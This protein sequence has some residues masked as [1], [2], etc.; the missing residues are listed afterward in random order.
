MK[1]EYDVITV[2]GGL[3]GAA[4]AKVLADKGMRVLVVERE[5]QFKDRIRGEYIAPWGVAEAERIGLADTLRRTCAHE[6]PLF[7]SQGQVRDLRATT[8]QGLPAFTLYHPAMQEAVLDAARAA[9]AEVWRGATVSEVRPGAPPS[10]TVARGGDARSLTARLIVAADGR[11]SAA[12]GWGGFTTQRA[13]Q[14]LL[15]AGVMLENLSVPEDTGHLMINSSIGRA[16]FMFPQ[17]DGRVRA[18]L[19]YG[20]DLG[21]IQGEKDTARFIGE[22]MKTGMPA[23]MYAGARAGGP[24]AS[25]DM[26]ETWV[27]HPYR[28]GLALLGDAAGSSDPTWGQGLSLT[29]R[30][31]RVLSDN[32]LSTED[33]EAAGHSYA[34]ARDIYFNTV[35]SV[36]QWWFDLFLARGGEAEQR[37]ARALPLLK[38]EPDRT[39]DHFSGGPEL[40]HDDNVR[41]R[42]F[43]EI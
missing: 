23:E 40:P 28:D 9:G 24:L 36:G 6:E 8:P 22:S 41:R 34:R 33:W 43:G 19:V 27:E 38:S 31:V 39:P 32:L 35:I 5:T 7:S 2:G 17:G 3:G 20:S 21:R 15:G 37:R 4:L 30:D 16:A 13:S 1:T 18:Y 11:S 25:F 29:M 10:V 42:F 12:R 26:T 14:K